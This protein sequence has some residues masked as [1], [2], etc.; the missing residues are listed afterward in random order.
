MQKKVW[1][2]GGTSDS[3]AIARMLLIK[4]VP[5]VVSV[6]TP[7]ARNLY[8]SQIKVLIGC[9]N[10]Q[11]M[12]SFCWQENITS[13]IDASHPY[14]VE[15][16]QNAIAVAAQLN[17]SYLRYERKEYQTSKIED[18]PI[19]E[20]D[21]FPTLLA[22]DYLL[23]QRTLLTIGCKALNQFKSWQK[24]AIL[25]ARVLPRVESL[26]TALNADFTSDRIIAMRPRF[27]FAFEKALWQQWNISLV[28][29]KASGIAGG[30]N[31]KR[32]VAT[33]LNIPLI[34]IGRPKINYPLKTSDLARVIDFYEQ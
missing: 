12:Q 15:V 5:F 3:V 26:K 18:S 16:S 33:D 6:A 27:N 2:V 25:Y 11:E 22:G 10:R 31:I 34:I 24:K 4:Q 23:Q 29:T 30:E 7:A 14:A 21:S 1:L 8:Q 20:L 9:L 13:I 19:I 17:I 32:Q 28:V